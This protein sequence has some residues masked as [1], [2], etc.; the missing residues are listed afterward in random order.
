MQKKL[1]KVFFWFIISTLHKR[2]LIS[3][4]LR[5]R[6]SYEHTTIR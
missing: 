2:V 3:K 5:G 1:D 4:L 6:R